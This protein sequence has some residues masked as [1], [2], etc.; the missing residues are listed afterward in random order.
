MTQSD[1]LGLNLFS[2]ANLLLPTLT[3]TFSSIPRY[4][5]LSFS[6]FLYV[7]QI[8][9]SWIKASIAVAFIILHVLIM[10]FFVQ[11]YFIS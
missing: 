9:Q 1:R 4:A 8:K 6:V 3:G 5:L 10:G 7:G 11:G 2:F